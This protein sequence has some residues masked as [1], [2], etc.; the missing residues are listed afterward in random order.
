MTTVEAADDARVLALVVAAREGSPDAF[1]ELVDRYRDPVM[2]LAYRLTRDPDEA[3]DVTQDAF[4]RAFRRIESF[5]PDRPFSRWLFVIAR[6]ASLDALR[7]KRRVAVPFAPDETG[8]VIGP[9][10]LT[11]RNEDALRL[12][13]ALGELPPNHRRALELYYFTGLRYRE[14]AGELGIPIGTVKTYIARAKRR[15]RERFEEDGLQTAA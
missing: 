7:R 1:G 12:H 8:A 2:R 15:L 3:K 13:V 9:E 14:I 10:E 6:N 5:R 4:L 11:V